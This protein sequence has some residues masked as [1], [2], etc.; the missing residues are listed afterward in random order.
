MQT[1]NSANT[2]AIGNSI[3]NTSPCKW[4]LLSQPTNLYHMEL[5]FLSKVYLSPGVSTPQYEELVSYYYLSLCAFII[6][7][8]NKLPS[9]ASNFVFC[10]H[11]T[12]FSI[13]I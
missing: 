8:A 2:V 7:L 4:I 13:I 3:L 6:F 5:P 11:P 1:C 10:G 9:Q 12:H